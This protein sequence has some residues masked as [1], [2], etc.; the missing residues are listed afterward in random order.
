[1][2]AKQKVEQS[3]KE[4]LLEMPYDA[5]SVSLVC[6]RAAV[7]RKT[8]YGYFHSKE[9]VVESYFERTVIEPLQSLN[10]ILGHL[11]VDA[12]SDLVH[13]KMYHSLFAD[14]EYYMRLVGNGLGEAGG[15][16]VRAVTNAVFKWNSAVIDSITESEPAWSKDYIG[17]F[18]ASSQAMFMKKWIQEGM[19][20]SPEDIAKLYERMT[21]S[22]WRHLAS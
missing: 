7:S 2:D 16:F 3:L 12:L 22:F 5:I 11:S 21:H 1:M 20:V 17:Y 10:D 4:L 8:F 9:D 6:K 19:V 15:V 13:E 18:F 14:R